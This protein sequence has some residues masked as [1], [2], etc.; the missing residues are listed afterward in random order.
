[1]IHASSAPTTASSAPTTASSASATAAFKISDSIK[2]MDYS[3]MR[4]FRE[5]QRSLLR[6]Q[7][8]MSLFL[9]EFEDYVPQSVDIGIEFYS[10]R[11]TI[12]SIKESIEKMDKFMSSQRFKRRKIRR[13]L[14]TEENR[15]LYGQIVR[16]AFEKRDWS[17]ES[18]QKG[19]RP[20]KK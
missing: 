3:D 10:L 8:D 20:I 16:N 11:R 19:L 9:E 2:L 17:Q 7:I 6:P 4:R 18:L 13:F 12:A 14:T 15:K 1:M 5:I